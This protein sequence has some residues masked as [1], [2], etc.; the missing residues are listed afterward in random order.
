MNK[1]TV[2]LNFPDV[3]V[4]MALVLDDHV[5]RQVAQGWWQA[6]DSA[7]G[8]MR[9]TQISLLRLLTTQSAMDG[10]PLGI[11]DAWQ[12][13]D[14]LF[15]DDRVIFIP[16]PAE[17]ERHFRK[18]A[19]GRAASP[20]LWADAWL[21]AFAKAAEGTLVTFDYALGARGAHCLLPAP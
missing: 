13:Y 9:F 15:Q 5:H 2:S 10:K 11:D 6:T 8:F 17:A 14:R 16:E 20:K 12:V 1:S 3:N 21:L 19:S 18:F 4:W 7:I